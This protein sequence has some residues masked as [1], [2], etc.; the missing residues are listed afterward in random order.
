[1]SCMASALSEPGG[2]GL[3]TLGLPESLAREMAEAAGFTPLPQARHRP[4]DQRLLRDPSVR[5]AEL[6]DDPRSWAEQYWNGEADLV[7]AHHPVV[8]VLGARPRRSTT[9]CS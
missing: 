6:H 5:G 3:G 4:P 8:P 2:A 9:G 1:M 7:H